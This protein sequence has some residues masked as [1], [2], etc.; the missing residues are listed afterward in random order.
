[1]NDPADHGRRPAPWLIGGPGRS[2]KTT[3]ALA[4][5]KGEGPVAGFPL[6]GLFTTYLKRRYLYFPPHRRAL[7]A[8]YLTRSRYTGSDR[9]AVQ[10]PTEFLRRPL[11]DILARIPATIGHRIDLIDWAL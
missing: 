6:E 3:L 5:N 1:M 9:E 8:E 10:R 11:Q 2:G 4:L 7:L